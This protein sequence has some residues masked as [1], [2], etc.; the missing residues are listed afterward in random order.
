MVSRLGF[1]GRQL[2]T[3]MHYPGTRLATLRKTIKNF[4]QAEQQVKRP[5]F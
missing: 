4:I 5:R 3:S 1:R 2:F